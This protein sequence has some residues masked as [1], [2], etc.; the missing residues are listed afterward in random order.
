MRDATAAPLTDPIYAPD[1]Y[2]CSHQQGNET[3]RAQ[4]PGLPYNSVLLPGNVCWALITPRPINS[5][6]QAAHFE[7]IWSGRIIS[8]NRTATLITNSSW[9]RR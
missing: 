6:I 7:M 5:V 9:H 2:T 8:V 1:D 4:Y 3:K